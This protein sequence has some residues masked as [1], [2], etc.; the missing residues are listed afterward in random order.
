MTVGVRVGLD[1]GEEVDVEVGQGV[2][3]VV[4]VGLDVGEWLKVCIGDTFANE[5]AVGC[6]V[7][8]AQT[9]RAINAEKKEERPA[10]QCGPWAADHASAV[11]LVP[12]SLTFAQLQNK[13]P[14]NDNIHKKRIR[15]P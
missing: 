13:R 5:G 14:Q 4:R 6:A 2:G 9:N 3:L 10:L 8:P 11:Q 7:Q 1:V 15:N 12:L